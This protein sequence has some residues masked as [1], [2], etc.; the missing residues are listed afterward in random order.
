AVKDGV[1]DAG[2]ES[3]IESVWQDLRYGSR[4]LRRSP[5][6]AAIAILILTLGI[7]ANTAIFSLLNA[8]M[9]RTLPVHEPAQLVEPLSRYPGEPRINGFSWEFFDYVRDR[10]H[11]FAAVS[12]V[13]PTRFQLARDAA[14]AETVDGEYVEGTLFSVLG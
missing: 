13:S 8:V 9:L 3:A 10:N 14:D 7:G 5:G 1:R 12:G 11:V 6:F 2:W 4:M